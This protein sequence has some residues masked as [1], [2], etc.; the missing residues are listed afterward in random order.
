MLGPRPGPRQSARRALLGDQPPGDV[1]SEGRVERPRLGPSEARS[2]GALRPEG[3][4]DP[5]IGIDLEEARPDVGQPADC[6]E[7]DRPGVAEDDE[8]AEAAGR[9]V[10]DRFPAIA[11]TW[12]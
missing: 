9:A 4:E 12:R 7:R 3:G 11:H 8:P 5:A 2:V 6:L 1:D 10:D